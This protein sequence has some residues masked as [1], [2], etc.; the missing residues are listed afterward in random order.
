MFAC[1][2]AQISRQRNTAPNPHMPEFQLKP[3]QI[4][5]A[6]WMLDMEQGPLKGSLLAND[7]GTGKTFMYLTLV[8]MA[9]MQLERRADMGEKSSSYLR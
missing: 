2:R 6:A 3:H 4:I 1:E 5:D 7:V 8:H 9:A